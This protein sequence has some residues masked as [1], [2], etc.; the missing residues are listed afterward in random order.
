MLQA[1][2]PVHHLY[3]LMRERERERERER[4]MI[5]EGT[6]K[7][8]EGEWWSWGQGESLQNPTR[9]EKASCCSGRHRLA[10]L[11]AARLA[12][13]AG[14]RTLTHTRALGRVL[15]AS[16]AMEPRGRRG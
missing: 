10:S 15:H 9:R 16:L 5:I 3:G 11:L 12:R 14:T 6:M 4:V 1:D 8:H 13:L 2:Q 7:K